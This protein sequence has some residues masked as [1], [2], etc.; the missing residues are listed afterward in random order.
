VSWVAQWA[1][2]R[3][4][5]G[6]SIPCERDWLPCE[7]QL[8]RCGPPV[9]WCCRIANR[10]ASAQFRTGGRH[11]RFRR[12]DVAK[13]LGHCA[14]VGR[15]AFWGRRA[16]LD[17]RLFPCSHRHAFRLRR[18]RYPSDAWTRAAE[19]AGR[20]HRSCGPRR[21]DLLRAFEFR[22]LAQ[23]HVR[24]HLAWPHHVLRLGHPL[25]PSD[26]SRRCAVDDRTCAG[27]QAT[28]PRP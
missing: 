18:I 9:S 13:G 20:L 27:V 17:A 6:L 1:A 16:F 2:Y 21:F 12:T 23:R 11:R 7:S 4:R 14:H 15:N 22:R 5:T 8:Q 3:Q 10:A 26:S 24:A 19:N 28:C 25:L